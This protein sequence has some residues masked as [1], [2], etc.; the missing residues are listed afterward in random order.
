MDPLKNTIK[1]Y[2]GSWPDWLD[3]LF[4]FKYLARQDGE[5]RTALH[6]AA[7]N[8]MVEVVESL[9]GAGAS[10]TIVDNCGNPPALACAKY[11]FIICYFVTFWNIFS[12]MKTRPPA[13]P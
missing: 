5:G 9:L 4:K 1:R 7:A 6:L 11:A 8:G 3:Q 12:G 2:P 13:W 10:V